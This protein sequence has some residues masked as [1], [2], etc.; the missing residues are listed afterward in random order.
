VVHTSHHHLFLINESYENNDFEFPTP[1]CDDG[2]FQDENI[3]VPREKYPYEIFYENEEPKLRG[4]DLQILRDYE[5]LTNGDQAMSYYF[6]EQPHFGRK[7]RREAMRI[8]RNFMNTKLDFNPKSI[9]RKYKYYDKQDEKARSTLKK[10]YKQLKRIGQISYGFKKKEFEIIRFRSEVVTKEGQVG[11]ISATKVKKIVDQLYNKKKYRDSLLVY[12]MFTVAARPSDITD[13]RFEDV[14]E[15]DGDYQATIF[16]SKTGK[17]KTV[18]IP[19]DLFDRIEEYKKILKD[20]KKYKTGVRKTPRDKDVTGH[21]IFNLTAGSISNL[22]Y[23]QFDGSIS[24]NLK[25]RSKDMR[26]S[27]LNKIRKDVN[28]EAATLLANH[29]NKRITE[30]HY[31][32]SAVDLN[33][34][35]KQS[36]KEPK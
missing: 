9:A 18:N 29:S 13:V 33:E 23:K 30:T 12:F 21:F 25:C 36:Q 26:I 6:Y 3:D 15:K 32:R 4:E 28:V 8:Y 31:L 34:K 22:F 17:I 16:Q 24:K 19:K 20:L 11:T 2:N 1:Q 10:E 5:K 14:V 7:T 35:A 27:A